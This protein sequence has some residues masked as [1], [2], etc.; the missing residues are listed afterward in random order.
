MRQSAADA[1]SHQA[2]DVAS[3]SVSY[4]S[5]LGFM[6]LYRNALTCNCHSNNGVITTLLDAVWPSIFFSLTEELS[7]R[8]VLPPGICSSQ[9]EVGTNVLFYWFSLP[10]P[11]HTHFIGIIAHSSHDD[12]A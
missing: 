6:A 10:L 8:L 2:D 5:I 9:L 7:D 3:A 4:L 12:K 1:N 11:V